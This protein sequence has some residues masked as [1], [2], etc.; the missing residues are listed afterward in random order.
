[1]SVVWSSFHWP[2]TLCL[3]HK[4]TIYQGVHITYFIFTE[5]VKA[6]NEGIN[7]SCHLNSVICQLEFLPKFALASEIQSLVPLLAKGLHSQGDDQLV[8]AT[9]T[10]LRDIFNQVFKWRST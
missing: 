5:L 1:M 7:P 9:L 6:Y 4:K 2:G 10:S 8:I 3:T